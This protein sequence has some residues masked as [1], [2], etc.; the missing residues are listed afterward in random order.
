MLQRN[1]YSAHNK[2]FQSERFLSGGRVLVWRSRGF[3]LEVQIGHT[4]GNLKRPILEI[5]KPKVG[6]KIGNLKRGNSENLEGSKLSQG[7]ITSIRTIYY[8]SIRYWI[9]ITNK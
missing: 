1:T 7:M 9:L 5:W 6:H 3:N 8:I 2:A 4:I